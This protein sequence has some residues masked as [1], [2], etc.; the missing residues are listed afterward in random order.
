MTNNKLTVIAAL[1]GVLVAGGVEAKKSDQA[2]F[3]QKYTKKSYIQTENTPLYLVFESYIQ[4]VRHKLMIGEFEAMDYVVD[5]LHLGHTDDGE[6]RAKE[7]V[8]VFSQIFDKISE[9]NLRKKEAVLCA[10]EPNLKTAVELVR[11]LNS[12]D[13]IGERIAKKYYNFTKRMISSQERKSLVDKLKSNRLG[14]FY[15]SVDY[16][17]LLE[18]TLESVQYQVQNSC[19]ELQNATQYIQ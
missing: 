13:D 14:F 2:D 7:L 17:F 6:E 15:I 3:I 19:W 18:E 12:M 5:T 4:T 11:M 10:D 16:R 1:F 8:G 9:E